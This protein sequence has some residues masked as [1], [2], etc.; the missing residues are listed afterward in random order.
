MR[1]KGREV[2]RKG[3][4]QGQDANGVRRGLVAD[5]GQDLADRLRPELDDGVDRVR[6]G[7]AKGIEKVAG[8]DAGVAVGGVGVGGG[9]RRGLWRAGLE[10]GPVDLRG[11]Q[12]R[13]Q[14][15][16]DETGSPIPHGPGS[17]GVL[18]G[19][20]AATAA[21]VSLARSAERLP[22]P[23]AAGA[24][25]SGDPVA[26]ASFSGELLQTDVLS[27]WT[28][29]KGGGHPGRVASLCVGDHQRKVL[30]GDC[31]G[32]GLEMGLLALEQKVNVGSPFA[33]QHAAHVCKA[34]GEELPG[35]SE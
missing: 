22:V 17:L 10:A 23:G 7:L 26:L 14:A 30:R 8:D 1:V 16:G 9:E 34:V 29:A 19:V 4:Q 6:A 15:P 35:L 28:R 12:E 2:A 27:T 18:A 20:V 3:V 13:I 31:V 11:G 25:F 24:S 21:P 33:V 5:S 32:G